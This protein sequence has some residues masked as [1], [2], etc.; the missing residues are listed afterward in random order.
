[1]TKVFLIPGLGADTRLYKNIVLPSG[2]ER[3]PVDWVTPGVLDILTTYGQKLV[4]HY[5]I[6]SGDIVIGDS[7]GGMIAVEIAKQVKLQKVILISSIKTADEAPWYFKLFQ[8]VPVYKPIPAS[9]MTKVGFMVKPIFGDMAAGD[10]AIFQ[11]MLA[12]SSPVFLKWAMHAV[13]YFNNTESI[14]NLFHIIGDKDQ[15]FPWKKIKDPTAII[16]GG[17]H[18]M[19]FDRATEINKL[20]ADILQQ[21]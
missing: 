16:K 12:N 7:L 15:V 2:F 5:N 9:I 14:P 21:P 17:T 20:L 19:V 3:L 6:Q 13:L 4:K 1:M 18:I 8:K 10:L 11:S